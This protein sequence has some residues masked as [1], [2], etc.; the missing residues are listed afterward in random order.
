MESLKIKLQKFL[1]LKISK[2]LT[3]FLI[4]GSISTIIS[5]LVFSISVRI[6]GI[7]YIIANFLAFAISIGFG[8]YLN[9]R[10]SFGGGHQK[11]SHI[12]E[13]LTVYC[14]SLLLGTLILKIAVDFFGAIPELG[15]VISLCFTTCTNF[16]GIKFFVFKK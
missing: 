9:K 2:Q 16:I 12:L 13:Y 7:Y 8:Y 6:F 3:R 15:F 5:Y 11:S 14:S 4:T 1:G 10:W